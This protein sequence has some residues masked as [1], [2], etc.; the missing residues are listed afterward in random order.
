[1]NL[2][3]GPLEVARPTSLTRL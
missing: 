3:L 2:C 1:M